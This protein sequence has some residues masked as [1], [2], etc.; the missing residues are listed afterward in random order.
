MKIN[1]SEIISTGT[2]VISPGQK[3]ELTLPFGDFTIVFNSEN[4]SGIMLDMDSKKIYVNDENNSSGIGAAFTIPLYR[5]QA[6]LSL[7]VNSIGSEINK[8]RV[9]NFTYS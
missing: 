3:A 8:T 4:I 1:G 7:V 9:I 2:F 6:S 5:G